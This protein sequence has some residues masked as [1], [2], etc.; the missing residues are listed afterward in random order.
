LDDIDLGVFGRQKHHGVQAWE[1]DYLLYNAIYA[2]LVKKVGSRQ[3]LLLWAQ[4]VAKIAEGFKKRIAEVVSK[5]GPHKQEFDTFLEGLRQTLNPSVDTFEA[6]EMLAQHLITKP[7]FE[8]L[9]ENYS[10]VKNNPVSQSLENMIDVLEDQ[11]LEKDRIVLDRFYKTVKEQVSGIDNAKGRQQIIVRLYDNFFKLAMPKAVEKLGIVYT[12]IEIV[13][14][15]INSVSKVL[16]TEFKRNISDENVHFLDP[17]TGTGTFITRLI[18]S[19]LLGEAL[20][21]KYQSVIHANEMILLAY[22]IASVNIENAY[23]AAMGEKTA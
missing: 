5:K 14:F 21:Q 3:D 6:I 7:V 18:E 2:R 22:Y 15:I 9:F 13:D 1:K 12:P 8:A 4:D 17:F 23:H 19:G 16:K 11:G 10:F 20:P